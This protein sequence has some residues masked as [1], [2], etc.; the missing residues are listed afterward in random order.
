MKKLNWTPALV[1]L[2]TLVSCETLD[3]LF[4]TDEPA[5]PVA[6]G[7]AVPS[8]VLEAFTGL[9]GGSAVLTWCET[10]EG[11][12]ALFSQKGKEHFVLFSTD[13]QVVAEGDDDA[14]EERVDCECELT[15]DNDS[16]EEL[17]D[18]QIIDLNNIDPANFAE[19]IDNPLFPLIRGTVYTYRFTNDEGVEEKVVTEVTDQTKVVLGIDCTVVHDQEFEDGELV[20]DTYDWYAQDKDGNVWYLG[21]DTQ[22]LEDGKVISTD[23]A[24]EAGVDGA[25]P[26]IIMLVDPQPGQ[27]YRQEY[28][29]GEAEDR[30]EVVS[31][32]HTVTVPY[33]TFE[34]CLKVRET[35]PLEPDVLEFK[36]YAPGVG[37][38]QA[39]DESGRPTEELITRE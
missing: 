12:V 35:T 19:R 17:L 22:E 23:G 5:C 1:V 20:E 15:L 39:Q 16:E 3:D 18:K 33:G 4:D 37:F 28:Y 11:Y 6:T 14:I 29:A 24:W 34:N 30:A 13:G 7:Q 36:Y 21:E 31:I 9:Y 10:D 26:G 2:A 8:V 38:I 25:E 27:R 32:N